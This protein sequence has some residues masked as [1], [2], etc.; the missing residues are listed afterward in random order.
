MTDQQIEQKGFRVTGRVQGVFFRAWTQET[1][2]ELGLQ[3]TVRNRS[4]GSVEAHVRG[5]SEA[6][7]E[8]QERLW[9]GPPGARVEGVAV[10]GS[11]E[12]LP[13]SGF[14]VIR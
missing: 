7:E 2:Q 13:E 11:E 3:G 5:P 1:A 12:D 8:F 4:D 10:K 14:H 9:E 6:L